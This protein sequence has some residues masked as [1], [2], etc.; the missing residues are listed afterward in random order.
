[1]YINFEPSWLQWLGP[2]I[3]GVNL[4]TNKLSFRLFS[5]AV[6]LDTADLRLLLLKSGGPTATTN[7]VADLTPGTNEL[8]VAGYA[9]QTLANTIITEDDTNNFAYL[10]ADDTVF[11]GLATGET[12]TWAVLFEFITNDAGSFVYAGYDVTD[13]PTNGSNVTIQWATP[14]NG[15]VLKGDNI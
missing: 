8:T 13:T 6:N 3:V 9:R 2:L 5:G 1:M 14:A 11:T 4:V 12:I 10:D 15:G 7:V